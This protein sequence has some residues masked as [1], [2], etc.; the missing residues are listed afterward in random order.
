MLTKIIGNPTVITMTSATQT[1][2]ITTFEY[3]TV[4]GQP[5]QNIPAT[6][7]RIATGTQPAFVGL[8]TSTVTSSTGLLI[9]ANYAEHFKIDLVTTSSTSTG[10]VIYS[11]IAATVSVLQA[12]SGGLVSIVAVA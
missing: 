1:V 7:I 3:G 6:K 10:R 11:P 12:G 2:S 4:L 9:P 8:N 5:N